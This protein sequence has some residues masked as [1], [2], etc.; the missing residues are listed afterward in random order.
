[1]TAFSVVITCTSLVLCPLTEPYRISMQSESEASCRV[2]VATV[3]RN[4]HFKPE[5]FHIKCEAK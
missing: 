3:M 5:L 4:M 1:M 2:Y